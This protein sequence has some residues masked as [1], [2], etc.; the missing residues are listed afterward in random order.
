[1]AQLL[2]VY[3]S[4]LIPFGNGRRYDLVVDDGGRFLRVQCKTGHLRRGCVVFNAASLHS[5]RGG[6][7]KGYRGDAELFGVYCPQT[8][9]VYLVP[10]EDVGETIVA[11]RL[12]PPRNN[13]RKGIRLAAQYELN[14]PA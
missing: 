14:M 6:S 11:L 2:Q 7:R 12:E 5:H 3:D 10:V 13:Q 8:H 9:K 4:I 1:M